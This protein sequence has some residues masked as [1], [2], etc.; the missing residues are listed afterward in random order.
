MNYKLL[1]ITL[2]LT[3]Q[4]NREEFALHKLPKH[5]IGAELGVWKGDFTKVLLNNVQPS[6]L[7]LIDA[8]QNH[9]IPYKNGQ[10]EWTEPKTDTPQNTLDIIFNQVNST[11]GKQENI[12]IIREFTNKAANS[13]PDGSLDWVYIDADH[14]YE[15][16]LSD[17]RKYETK[18]KPGGIIWGH[19]FVEKEEYI[20]F[21]VNQAVETFLEETGYKFL[22][23]T[24][25]SGAPGIE[26]PSFVI[27]KP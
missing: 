18:V 17:L 19:D 6:K 27:Q 7:Y 1:P 13:I 20:E 22:G 5:S 10:K 25:E 23:L 2:E 15:G 14:S 21:G 4:Y 8:W 11:L 26:N 24:N 16:C 3:F 12:E 9:S